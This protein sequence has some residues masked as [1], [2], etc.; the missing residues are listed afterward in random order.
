M[1]ATT[2]KAVQLYDASYDEKTDFV[3]RR[4]FAPMRA[5]LRESAGVLQGFAVDL[6]TSTGKGLS[7]YEGQDCKIF[8]VDLSP[9]A[10]SA[11]GLKASNLGLDFNP[12][13]SDVATIPLP[14]IGRAHV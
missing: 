11:A 6:A 4:L 3:E 8:G 12:M 14:E 13:V 10:L 1:E 9:A 7:L 5:K 2:E